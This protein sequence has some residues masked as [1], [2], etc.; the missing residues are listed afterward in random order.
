M[1]H[2]RCLVCAFGLRRALCWFARFGGTRTV[3]SRW[4]AST[5][6]NVY[7]RVLIIGAVSVILFVIGEEASNIL[8]TYWALDD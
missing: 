8:N 6:C 4:E 3:I 2:I 1:W 5:A 7:D